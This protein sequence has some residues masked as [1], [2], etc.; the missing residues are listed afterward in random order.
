MF[1]ESLGFT[2]IVLAKL[3]GSAKGGVILGICEELNIPIRCI[4]IGE[5]MDDLREFNARE[6]V[7]AL[8][9]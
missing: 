8:F 5:K 3:D 1:Q 7:E 6:F 9:D 4:G 2:G